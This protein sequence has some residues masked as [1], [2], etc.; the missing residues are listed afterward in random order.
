MIKPGDREKRIK[1]GAEVLVA[2]KV[3]YPWDLPFKT[4]YNTR[5]NLSATDSTERLG[6]G[7]NFGF[8][9]FQGIATIRR[10]EKHIYIEHTYYTHLSELRELP[11]RQSLVINYF[12]LLINTK[13]LDFRMWFRSYIRLLEMD[14]MSVFQQNQHIQKQK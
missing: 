6:K 7:K 9:L 5:R 4:A 13:G 14:F 2:G 1:A 8:V 12:W 11:L 3:T 10:S